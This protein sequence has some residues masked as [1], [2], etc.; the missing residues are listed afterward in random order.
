MSILVASSCNLPTETMPFV[1]IE[2][3]LPPSTYTAMAAFMVFGKDPFM[4]WVQL[5]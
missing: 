4:G 1:T 3:L 2:V 5:S